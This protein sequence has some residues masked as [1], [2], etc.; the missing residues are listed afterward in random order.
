[1]KGKFSVWRFIAYVG[2]RPAIWGVVSDMSR[3][4]LESRDAL[5]KRLEQWIAESNQ[6]SPVSVKP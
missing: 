6:S 3:A 2:V 1:R 5:C 4:S